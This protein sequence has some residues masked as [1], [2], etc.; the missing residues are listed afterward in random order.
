MSQQK[1]QLINATENVNLPGGIVVSGVTTAGNFIGSFSGTATGLSGTPNITLGIVTA[2]SFSGDGSNLTGVG[3]TPFIGVSTAAQSGTTTIDLS[4]GNV[5]YFTQDTDTTVAFANTTTTQVID[6]IRVKDDTTTARTITWPASIIW[7][8]GTAPTLIDSSQAGEVQIFNLT[9]RDQGVTWYGYETMKNDPAEPIPPNE[10]YI[11]GSN[12]VGQLGLNDAIYRSSPTQLPGTQ[13]T[14]LSLDGSYGSATK[15]DGSLWVWGGNGYGE[16]G[17][18]NIVQ[19]SSPIQIP[20]TQWSVS[21]YEKV[22]FVWNAG[23]SFYI[24]TDGTLW[25]SGINTGTTGLLGVN[26]TIPRS[27]PIQIPGTQWDKMG[28]SREGLTVTKTD[29]TLW[30]IGRNADS[31]ST[32]ISGQNN[33]VQHSSPVQISGT[34]WNQSTGGFGNMFAT[35]TDGTLWA[36][37]MNSALGV[38]LGLLG[39]NDHVQRSS[40]TQ[41][42]GTQWSKVMSSTYAAIA[43]KTDGTLW[44]WGRP[45]SG[46]TG[47]SSS[48]ATSSPTQIPGTQW[49][50][51]LISGRHNLGATKTDGTLW[52]WGQNIQGGLGINDIINRSSPIQLP[53]TQ[54]NSRPYNFGDAASG[55]INI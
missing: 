43:V 40:P 30:F 41:L 10:F 19:Y 37:G 36:W 1:A 55:Y 35:K 11:T 44:A 42:P 14:G 9:T 4:L 3:V 6:F 12:S 28:H 54:W 31:Y 2:T 18:N 46:E 5:I 39:L 13:W 16:L 29:G 34:Q 45:N 49:T 52:V 15:T 51:K 22:S 50:S 53:G 26:D 20:G 7:N 21:S 38:Y 47:L 32:G 24:K 23:I 27:S 48:N 17:L 33:A 25:G 8:G